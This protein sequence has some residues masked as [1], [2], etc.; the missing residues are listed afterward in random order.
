M[1]GT[2]ATAAF[3][4]RSARRARARASG[5]DAVIIERTGLQPEYN[6][7]ETWRTSSP[8]PAA[9][10]RCLAEELSPLLIELTGSVLVS[11]LNA[12]PQL[13]RSNLFG[14]I[15]ESL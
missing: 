3:L 6:L 1:I 8:E 9:A 10:L 7:P 15:R 12:N 4:R 11:R 14:A 13:R 2:A 5:L